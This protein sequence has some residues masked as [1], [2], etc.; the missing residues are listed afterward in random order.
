MVYFLGIFISFTHVHGRN[1]PF[2]QYDLIQPICNRDYR[3]LLH[4]RKLKS[5]WFAPFVDRAW[6]PNWVPLDF[7]V[8]I[9]FLR[10][11]IAGVDP[12]TDGRRD[13][14]LRATCNKKFI[15]E[16][17]IQCCLEMLRNG[18]SEERLCKQ[19]HYVRIT[20][21]IILLFVEE[22]S[23]QREQTHANKWVL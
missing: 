19:M 6:G 23:H 16:S 13:F 11:H 4:T 8:Y 1:V 18:A 20:V 7:L 17:H 14:Y 3:Y 22:V 5:P 10:S 9:W 12:L 21:E 15:C 2:I